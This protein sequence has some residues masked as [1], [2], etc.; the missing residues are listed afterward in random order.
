MGF[1]WLAIVY[2]RMGDIT[3]AENYLNKSGLILTPEEKIPELY[4]SNTATANENTPLGWA[5]SLYVVALVEI[6]RAR[7]TQC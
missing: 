7:T 1:P 2:A 5:E 3:R 6:E 4:Y